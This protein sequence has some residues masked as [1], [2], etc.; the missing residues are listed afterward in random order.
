MAVSCPASMC[1]ALGL[2]LIVQGPGEAAG[3]DGQGEEFQRCV[4]SAVKTEE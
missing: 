2:L 1:W 3:S 4:L